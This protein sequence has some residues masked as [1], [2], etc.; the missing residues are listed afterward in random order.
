MLTSGCWSVPPPLPSLCLALGELQALWACEPGIR[1]PELGKSGVQLLC[2]ACVS[3]VCGRLQSQTVNNKVRGQVECR[4][5]QQFGFDLR[6]AGALCWR[7][8]SQLACLLQPVL[9]LE[10][11]DDAHSLP[12]SPKSF[13]S[14]KLFD[15]IR[16]QDTKLGH[17]SVSQEATL[18]PSP[19]GPL[20][21]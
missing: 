11:S 21:G 5:V 6:A 7:Q 19:P 12:A 20:K 18:F 15:P 14:P 10:L 8:C 9:R 3:D 16:T 13:S 1:W 2:E 17:A 4:L